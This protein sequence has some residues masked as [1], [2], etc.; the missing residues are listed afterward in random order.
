MM[1]KFNSNDDA[2]ETLDSMSVPE[3]SGKVTIDK[4]G[5]DGILVLGLESEPIAK[6]KVFPDRSHSYVVEANFGFG[7]EVRS[8]EDKRLEMIGDKLVRATDAD[9]ELPWKPSK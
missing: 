7:S 5:D 1:L 2:I 9:L 3:L 6:V 8:D 4:I